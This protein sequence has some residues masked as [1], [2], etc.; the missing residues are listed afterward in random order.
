MTEVD[1]EAQAALVKL[2]EHMKSERV[3]EYGS[4]EDMAERLNCSTRHYADME[5]GK[6]NFR[7]DQLLKINKLFTIPW[8]LF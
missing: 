3:L 6:V 5:K 8:E 4:Q 2:G 7:F 1:I